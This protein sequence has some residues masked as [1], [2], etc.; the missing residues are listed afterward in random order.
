MCAPTINFPCEFLH[1][2]SLIRQ[3]LKSNPVVTSC[4]I[5]DSSGHPFIVGKPTPS[6][7]WPG[8]FHCWQ[9]AGSSPPKDP[10]S[11]MKDWKRGVLPNRLLR[12]PSRSS[13]PQALKRGLVERLGGTSELVPFPFPSLHISSS[14]IGVLVLPASRVA[15]RF[16]QFRPAPTILDRA[17]RKRLQ[18]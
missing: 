8:G 13:K 10:A 4:C 9:D 17:C 16:W 7:Y 11:S 6:F 5:P 1:F 3:R 12:M 18:G 2:T 14:K 15:G